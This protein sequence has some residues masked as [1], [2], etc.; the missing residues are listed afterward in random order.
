MRF[1]SN[2]SSGLNIKR[3]T[4]S[5]TTCDDEDGNSSPTSSS[6]KCCSMSIYDY[7]AQRSQSG[8]SSQIT[9]H[10]CTDCV[11]EYSTS[12]MD[13]T[14]QCTDQ[15][16]IITCSDPA[17]GDADTCT[18][19]VDT[20]LSCCDV[21]C[22]DECKGCD[23]LE[24]FDFLPYMTTD[25]TTG[26]HP[27]YLQSSWDEIDALLCSCSKGSGSHV[28]HHSPI[29]SPCLPSSSIHSEQQRQQQQQQGQCCHPQPHMFPP[30]S[31]SHSLPSPTS[32]FITPST[33][34]PLTFPTTPSSTTSPTLEDLICMWADCQSRF[35]SMET[36]INHISNQHLIESSNFVCE[37][38][39]GNQE[40][41]CQVS[42]LWG[43]CNQQLFADFVSTQSNA[44]NHSHAHS[45]VDALSM[46]LFEDHLNLRDTN[47][48][49]PTP[50]SAHLVSVGVYQ[51]QSQGSPSQSTEQ[52]M[53][54]QLP[55]EKVAADDQH[56]LSFPRTEDVVNMDTPSSTSSPASPHSSPFLPTPTLS[57]AC[58]HK[59][60]SPSSPS[61]FSSFPIPADGPGE[62]CHAGEHA[63]TCLWDSCGQTFDSCSALTEHLTKVHVGSGKQRYECFWEGCNR[64]SR[65]EGHKD[66]AKE[67][68]FTSKQKICRHL[69]SHT[70]H[71][72]YQCTV[73]QQNFSEA[74]TLQQHM[75]RH[76]REKPYV[77]DYPGCGKAFAI[78][79][80]LTI[81]KRTHNGQKPFKCSFCGRAFAESSNLSKH[82][83]THTGVR[84]Y[85]CSVPGCGKSF[86]R[87]DQ[88]TRHAGVHQKNRGKQQEQQVDEKMAL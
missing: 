65:C 43:D 81:H 22:Q 25:T 11:S 45:H 3:T 60:S 31:Q 77:C 66:R 76:T 55:E 33:A 79:G 83:R 71:R 50:P 28:T 87:P 88:L 61:T 14:S 23:E 73:C 78:A 34:P 18:G 1:L 67:G 64:N 70:G 68:G 29:A 12:S 80:A 49:I 10:E 16:V 15:C 4:A 57:G 21:W 38:G 35:S 27:Q 85:V 63:H 13:M 17:H 52:R 54:L 42:C 69:Q 47:A 75:R 24:N 6:F 2:P 62:P 40:A 44:D 82:L 8:A 39:S 7:A 9:A 53:R 5:S 46:H 20:G 32:F 74:A 30:S 36:L 59:S 86:A 72:P 26:S 51:S 48:T 41:N 84:P 37:P 58:H 19:A 56:D